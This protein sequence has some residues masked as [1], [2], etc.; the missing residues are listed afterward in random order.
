MLQ[1]R[2]DYKLMQPKYPNRFSPTYKTF[3][4]PKFYYPIGC[5]P[6][7]IYYVQLVHSAVVFVQVSLYVYD[8]EK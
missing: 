7:E 1:P 6:R 2:L 3:I 5:T 4:N 8:R